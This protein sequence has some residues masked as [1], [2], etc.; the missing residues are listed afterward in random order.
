MVENSLVMPSPDDMSLSELLAMPRSARLATM[1]AA[2]NKL[3]SRPGRPL[4]EEVFEHFL[5]G[6]RAGLCVDDAIAMTGAT[7]RGFYKRRK[8][9]PEFA[10]RWE[11]AYAAGAAPL[12]RR[13]QEIA[14]TGEPGSMATVRAIEIG[15]RARHGSLAHPRQAPP[16]AT[17]EMKRGADGAQSFT[18]TVGTPGIY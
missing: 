7:D 17:A 18:V 5:A 9:D 11:E 3:H 12:E 8:R 16:T 1:R 6:L 13:A 10:R 15:L 2:A 4:T 14:L